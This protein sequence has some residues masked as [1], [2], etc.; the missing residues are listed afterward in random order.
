[1]ASSRLDSLQ[2]GSHLLNLLVEGVVDY[3]LYM[4]GPTGEVVTWNPGAQRIKGYTAEEILGRNFSLFY[5]EEDRLAGA[6]HAALERALEQGRYAEEVQRVRKDGSVFWADVVI[7]PVRDETGSLIG[8]AKI[9]R[10]ITDRR[11]AEQAVVE[12]EQS[13]R[14]LIDGVTDHGLCLLSPDGIVKTWNEGSRRLRGYE[15]GEII[16]QHYEVFYLPEMRAQGAPM[17]ALAEALALGRF[18]EQG[19]QCRKDGSAFW[20]HVII[21]PVR[22]HRGVLA[23]YALL[24]RDVSRQKQIEDARAILAAAFEGGP[25]AMVILDTALRIRQLNGYLANLHG[26]PATESLVG[27]PLAVLLPERYRATVLGHLERLITDQG[28]RQF[29]LGTELA[30]ARRDGTEFPL[31]IVAR[32]LRRPD[33]TLVIA[34]FRDISELLA[35]EAAAAEQRRLQAVMAERA[36]SAEELYRLSQTLT[37]IIEASPLG[38]VGQVQGEVAIWNTAARLMFG[39]EDVTPADAVRVIDTVLTP[40]GELSGDEIRAMIR[41]RGAIRNIEIK[42]RHVSSRLIDLNISGA[43]LTDEQG[44]PDGYVYVLDDITRR[45][46]LD[47][48][49]RQSQ[50]MEAIGQ[51]TGG[52]AH[53]FNNLLAIIVGNLELMGEELPGDSEL[54]ELL[55]DALAAAI[56]GASLT[57]RLLA[58]SRQQALEPTQVELDQLIPNLLSVLHRVLEESIQIR[59]TIAPDLGKVRIDAHQ[60]ENAVLNLAVNARDAMPDGGVLTVSVENAVLDE[61]YA[62]EN[63]DVTAG[64]YVMVSVSDTGTGMSS[65]VAARALE[66]FFTTKPVGQGTGLGLSMVY[67]FVKQSGGHLKIYSEIGYGT[68]IKMYLPR[69]ESENAPVDEPSATDALPVS[70]EKLVLVVEDETPVRRLLLRFLASFG[71]RTLEAADGPSALELLK[72]NPAIDLLLTDVVM[73]GGLG[74]PALYREASRLYPNIGVVFMSGYAPQAVIKEDELQGHPILSKPFTRAALAEALERIS[75]LAEQRDLYDEGSK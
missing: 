26:Y 17:R 30:G 44:K 6:P 5:T 2:S 41:E 32:V 3:A 22:D 13:L 64:R 45:K 59:T 28:M 62:Q 35:E 27:K 54:R 10:D 60:L 65:E 40:E 58:Y 25:N 12:S 72:Q 18:E 47:E 1:M 29:R 66:P 36:R 61:G 51:L 4:L 21:E 43:L 50:K 70:G 33:E 55:D 49:L 57:H 71:H 56:R 15:A 46:Q 24:A 11:R 23:G 7:D 19:L 75:A 9:T 53:D 37:K 67:G 34:I 63:V 42:R 74:G 14:L 8:F 52:V 73:P 16:G 38:I 31:E 48:Q 39:L 69:V 20:A 68:T